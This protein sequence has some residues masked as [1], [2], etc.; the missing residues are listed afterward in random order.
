MKRN[1]EINGLGMPAD[2]KDVVKS[3]APKACDEK[4]SDRKPKLG[5]VRINEGDAWYVCP[6]NSVLT[7]D[8]WAL[9]HSALMYS[10]RADKNR[11]DVVDLDPYGTAA[12]FIDSAVQCI[13]DGGKICSGYRVFG[14]VADQVETIG[15]LCVTCTDLSVLAT[16]NYPE[17]WQDGESAQM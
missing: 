9:Q 5:M 6:F 8:E 2:P 10:H 17:K 14:P 4:T 11:V 12:P 7:F 16:T 3:A 1:V 15:L 13:N